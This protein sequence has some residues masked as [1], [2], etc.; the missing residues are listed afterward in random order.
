MRRAKIGIF[1]H[2]TIS[3]VKGQFASEYF[4]GEYFHGHDMVNVR[5]LAVVD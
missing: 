1:P 2:L 3:F 5:D 4:I